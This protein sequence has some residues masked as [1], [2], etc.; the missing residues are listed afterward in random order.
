MFKINEN[1]E[2]DRRILKY[3]YIRYSPAETSTINN[4]NSEVYINKPGE[5]SVFSSLYSYLELIFEVDK[6]HIITDMQMLMING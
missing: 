1:N 3:D 2:T 5:H 4:R 6:K